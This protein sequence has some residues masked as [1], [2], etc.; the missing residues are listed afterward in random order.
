[1]KP[2]WADPDNQLKCSKC[3]QTFSRADAMCTDESLL[4]DGDE[5]G[6]QYARVTQIV[7]CTRSSNQVIGR[8]ISDSELIIPRQIGGPNV[9][10]NSLETYHVQQRWPLTTAPY[11]IKR[12]FCPGTKV[13]NNGTRES[14]IDGTLKMQKTLIKDWCCKKCDNATGV[15]LIANDGS[16]WM[17]QETYPCSANNVQKVIITT[18]RGNKSRGEEFLSGVR[19]TTP[20]SLK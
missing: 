15:H 20:E 7:Y 2:F 10:Y 13:Y 14:N 9:V 4:L 3:N 12:G 11:T 19:Q 16:C 18:L 5:N 1:M 17:P 8:R 6:F